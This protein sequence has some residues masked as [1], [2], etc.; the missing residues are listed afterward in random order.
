MA[1]LKTEPS[2]SG[3]FAHRAARGMRWRRPVDPFLLAMSAVMQWEMT[4][5]HVSESVLWFIDQ[6]QDGVLAITTEG[7]IYL[8][9]RADGQVTNRIELAGR[10]WLAGDE[11]IAKMWSFC[12]TPM[13]AQQMTGGDG[14]LQ[15]SFT[16]FV[17][18]FE[19]FQAWIRVGVTTILSKLGVP[20]NENRDPTIAS[21]GAHGVIYDKISIVRTIHQ[22]CLAG[23]QEI[24]KDLLGLVIFTTQKTL[25]LI[26]LRFCF[27]RWIR[28]AGRQ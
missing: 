15:W 21:A 12:E 28:E 4:A 23:D 1:S 14:G 27:Y 6:G 20:E 2:Q 24:L 17:I 13:F 7:K 8:Y 5:D 25:D 18:D 22:A 3:M 11:L 26:D 9:E 16:R 19:E 10:T